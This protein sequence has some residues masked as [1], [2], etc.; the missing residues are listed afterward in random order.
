MTTDYRPDLVAPRVTMRDAYGLYRAWARFGREMTGRPWRLGA[1]AGWR[2][3]DSAAR[4]LL[5]PG[6]AR[7]VAGEMA[8]EYADLA[9]ALLATPAAAAAS[10]VARLDP[11]PDPEHDPV[12]R[13]LSGERPPDTVRRVKI[14]YAVAERQRMMLGERAGF[15]PDDP[16]LEMPPMRYGA[17]FLLPARVLDAS[18]AWASWFIPLEQARALLRDSVET[19]HQP[20]GAL[21]ALE[22][23]VVGSGAAMATMLCSDY[24]ASDFGVT[25]EIGLTLAVTPKAGCTVSD[26][27]QVFLRLIVTDAYSIAAARQIWGIRKDLFDNGRTGPGAR[28][29]AAEYAPDAVRWRIAPAGALPDAPAE[30]LSL[31]FP[32][33]GS[34]RSAPAPS[35]IYSMPDAPSAQGAPARAVLTRGG[36]REGVQF[37]GRVALSLPDSREAGRAAG[38]LC[39][40]GMS[41]L[42]ETLRGLGLDRRA[43]AANG[44]TERMTAELAAPIA[45]PAPAPPPAVQ[46]SGKSSE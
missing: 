24:R 5:G 32:R 6:D 36:A 13:A 20:A 26:P 40:G 22:P 45:G 41:C 27:G 44:W 34:G 28:R 7:A 25:Q 33:F 38:C 37:G 23:V 8:R 3:A 14:D 43:P 21:D 46:D 31:A 12:E 18:Q 15:A 30:A 4:G 9:A 11:P 19:G 29:L 39:A 2:M 16:A 10:A 35:L 17:P 42:C 1:A